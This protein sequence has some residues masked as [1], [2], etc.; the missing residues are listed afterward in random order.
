[1]NR[2]DNN[3]SSTVWHDSQQT[4]NFVLIRRFSS[5]RI[6]SNRLQALNKIWT[7]D[8][9]FEFPSLSNCYYSGNAEANKLHFVQASATNTDKTTN[10]SITRNI[11]CLLPKKTNRNWHIIRLTSEQLIL[12]QIHAITIEI[13]ITLPY[14]STF[15]I[16]FVAP[17]SQVDRQCLHRSMATIRDWLLPLLRWQ[18]RLRN[19]REYYFGL[20]RSVAPRRGHPRAFIDFFS[21]LSWVWV[22]RTVSRGLMNDKNMHHTPS[23]GDDSKPTSNQTR[24]SMAD[25]YSSEIQPLI[26]RNP[27]KILYTLPQFTFWYFYDLALG[28]E[29]A[30][31][32]F[33]LCFSV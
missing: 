14:S 12:T 30:A 2:C 28:V 6:H 13:S 4:C 27:C 19:S 15:I 21:V 23:A 3:C 18:R 32:S 33:R 7:S 26:L 10:D 16:V 5:S 17:S 1:M 20:S 24:R 25:T 11:Q 8:F 22:E 9:H 31:P 29:I